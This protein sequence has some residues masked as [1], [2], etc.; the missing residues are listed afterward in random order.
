MGISFDQDDD[1]DADDGNSA[2]IWAVLLD[3]AARVK[4]LLAQGDDVN[5]Q[6]AFGDTALMKAAVTGSA[7]IARLL[8]DAD[9]DTGLRNFMGRTA[10]EIADLNGHTEVKE[11]ITRHSRLRAELAAEEKHNTKCR[12]AVRRRPVARLKPGPR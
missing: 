1:L 2:L 5:A 4:S 7:A 10:T 12:V 9:A 3:S 8:L 6:N 11:I